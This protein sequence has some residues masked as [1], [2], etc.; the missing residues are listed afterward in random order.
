[1]EGFNVTR[2]VMGF[3]SQM[4]LREL[5]AIVGEECWGVVGQS[6]QVSI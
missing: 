4:L 6:T 5:S 1:M 3:I 2:E